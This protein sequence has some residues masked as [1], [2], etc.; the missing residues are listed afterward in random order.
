LGD[1]APDGVRFRTLGRHRLAGL[2]EPEELFQLESEGLL[3]EFRPAAHARCCHRLKSAI[4][5][6]LA[7]AKI[8]C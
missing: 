8:T 1:T 7:G 4:T 2:A 3:S 5:L 6:V